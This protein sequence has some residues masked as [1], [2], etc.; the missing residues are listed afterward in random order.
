MSPSQSRAGGLE[1]GFEAEELSG[2]T[3]LSLSPGAAHRLRRGQVDYYAELLDEDGAILRRE[4]LFEL[5]AGAVLYGLPTLPGLRWTVLGRGVVQL[6]PVATADL[7]PPDLTPADL[8]PADLLPWLEGL[9]G[10]LERS[11]RG[12]GL[13]PHHLVAGEGRFEAA[14]GEHV[15][16][17]AGITWGRF[18][19]SPLMYL[20][21][22]ALVPGGGWVFFPLSP[23]TWLTPSA[24]VQVEPLALDDQRLLA[25]LP[26]AMEHFHQ[27]VVELVK[28]SWI[29]AFQQEQH[30]LSRRERLTQRER[31]AV[32][33]R[34]STVIDGGGEWD[35][36]AGASPLLRVCQ[37]IGQHL[38]VR[39]QAPNLSI[40]RGQGVAAQV[41]AISRRSRL[42]A[43][44]VVLR[45]GWWRRETRPMLAFRS[46]SGKPVA[47]LPW[48]GGQ[49]LWDPIQ[50]VRQAEHGGQRLRKIDADSALDVGPVAYSFYRVLPDRPLRA[51][52][53]VRFALRFCRRD[54]L[55]AL[56][57]SLCGVIMA[58]LVPI[59]T[60]WIV[61]I[62]IPGHQTSQLFSIALA[63]LIATFAIFSLKI[64][65]DISLLRFEGRL[66]ETL[67][68]AVLDRLLRMP[69]T[70]FRHY[71]AGDLA[72]RV[73]AIETVET[74][75]SEGL[76]SSLL[77]GLLSLVNFALLFYI[78]PKAAAVAA[79]LVTVLMAAFLLTAY[80]QKGFWLRI[81]RLE[82]Q[83]ASMILQMMHGMH[84]VRLAGSEDRMFVRWGNLS[85]RFRDVL[86]HCY[87]SEMRF[88]VFSK[89]F[90][91]LCFAILFGVM[92]PIA[93]EGLSTGRF[94]AF[95]AAFAMVLSGLAEMARSVISSM[96]VVP[97]FE[98]LHPLL[99]A[100]PESDVERAH[101]GVLDGRL[102]I[103]ELTFRYGEGM[104][105][106]LQ[107]LSL[108]AQVG[109]SI[110]IVGPSGCG[111]STLLRLILGFERPTVG[112]IYF[113]GKDVA[114]LDLR[115]VRHQIGVVL[116]N[117][118]LMEA[119]LF[120]N[121]RGDKE[122][123]MDEAWRAAKMAGIADDIE[124]MPLCMHTVV[125]AKGSDLSGGQVQRLLIARAL[126]SRPRILLLDEATSALDNVTQSLVTDSLD[127]LRITRITIAHRL[128]TV[129]QA[130]RI[131]V[132]QRGRVVEEGTYEKLLADQG[133]F[134]E[135]VHRQLH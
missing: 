115:E 126:A 10:V 87:N 68:P 107:G 20:E 32:L 61:D 46:D 63:L 85:M 48:R 76:M 38:G 41:E 130:D 51:G 92:A 5:A 22:V 2:A 30:R 119:S 57:C 52:D 124:A 18:E 37:H 82:G 70:F 110:A 99:H 105:W 58:M 132:M 9:C 80:L 109:E 93:R 56:L 50:A 8:T 7:A 60:G 83:L 84:R 134:A 121:I 103:N 16:S 42:R 65:E 66:A 114:G 27:V 122:I 79:L 120:H 29:A 4:H 26:Q 17:F 135:L 67:Q 53:L 6:E 31:L 78:A 86:N 55:V 54:L 100:V 81:H 101:P 49:A 21:E 23:H 24:S 113:D 73:Q 106:V 96:E 89:A 11:Y 112:S 128:S 125:S 102:E 72:E 44:Q 19:G 91:V 28:A 131:F 71:S 12:V 104:P 36:D 3:P 47:L 69:N 95:I 15:S 98:R 129:K 1:R 123:S 118:Q 74:R 39:V 127:H 133:F 33:S 77:S 64:C 45:D 117:D 59:A 75:L 90:Q 13:V 25:A 43:R 40:D 62:T 14:A 97:T 88:G 108:A 94:L 35:L 111:K 34:F 116:Q